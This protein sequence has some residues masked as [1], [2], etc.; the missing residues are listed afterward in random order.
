M[1]ELKNGDKIFYKDP[2]FEDQLRF[3]KFNNNLDVII[4]IGSILLSKDRE[5]RL[6]NLSKFFNIKK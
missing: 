2:I 6:K 5:L 4:P 1:K 3:N